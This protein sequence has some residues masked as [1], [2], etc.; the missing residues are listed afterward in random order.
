MSAILQ[1]RVGCLQK[2]V[3][4]GKFCSIQIQNTFEM[5]E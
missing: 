5:E 2:G 1:K 4:D 3:Y